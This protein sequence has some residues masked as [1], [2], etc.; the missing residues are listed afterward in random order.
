M[1]NEN[2]DLPN[3]TFKIAEQADEVIEEGTK[4][5]E[6]ANAL[7]PS[8][9]KSRDGYDDWHS[10]L[11]FDPMFITYLWA[12]TENESLSGIPDRLADRPDL[13]TAMGFDPHDPP[14]GSTFRPK[15]MER[16]FG[17]LSNVIESVAEDIRQWG[18]ERGA[19]VG[20]DPLSNDD[21][22]EEEENKTPSKRTLNRL[23]RKNSKEVL[24]EIRELAIPEI[25]IPRP[26]ETIYDDDE[27][28]VLEA[29]LSLKVK[30]ANDA[31]T[32]LS[33][34]ERLLPN[35]VK[36]RENHGIPPNRHGV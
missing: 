10:S 15:R 34:L 4:W 13:A 14:S 29:L 2:P 9:Y 17:N 8:P 23:L 25:S 31:G 18:L 20:Y 36:Q 32:D 7:D 24:E 19:E 3:V 28:L 1:A 22:E 26:D 16:R 27:L 30:A 21:D 12:E 6:V 5:D 33:K 11:P 35:A